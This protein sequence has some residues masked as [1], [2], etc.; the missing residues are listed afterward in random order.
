MENAESVATT[1]VKPPS[2][3]YVINNVQQL[4][5]LNQNLPVS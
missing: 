2:N 4:F 5:S 1:P 3:Q